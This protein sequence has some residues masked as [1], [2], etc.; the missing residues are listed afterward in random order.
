MNSSILQPCIKYFNIIIYNQKLQFYKQFKL[1]F[2]VKN[3]ETVFRSMKNRFTG[4]F[5]VKNPLVGTRYLLET[6]IVCSDFKMLSFI[7]FIIYY[8]MYVGII[9]GFSNQK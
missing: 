6:Q 2:P 3:L 8:I 7:D 9:I 5:F 4:Q 1:I